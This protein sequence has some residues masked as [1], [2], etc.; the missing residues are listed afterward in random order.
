MQYANGY[1][2]K[3]G[4]WREDVQ[5]AGDFVADSDVTVNGTLMVDGDIRIEGNLDTE[6]LVCTGRVKVTGEFA[7]HRTSSA[8]SIRAGYGHIPDNPDDAYFKVGGTC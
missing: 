3:G 8:K 5:V 1:N 7:C 6:K 4:T 2:G